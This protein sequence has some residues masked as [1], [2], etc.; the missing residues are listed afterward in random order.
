M[1]CP[2][3]CRARSG[4]ER[5]SR[6]APA[7]FGVRRFGLRTQLFAGSMRRAAADVAHVAISTM[8]AGAR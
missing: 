8:G 2:P 5:R 6:R 3:L 1:R 7:S 4:P